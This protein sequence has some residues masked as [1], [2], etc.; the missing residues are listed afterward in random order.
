VGRLDRRGHGVVVLCTLLL[1]GGGGTVA[2]RA[3]VGPRVVYDLM[4]VDSRGLAQPAIG[5]PAISGSGRFVA[6][7]VAGEVI[8]GAYEGGIV[9]RDRATGKLVLASRSTAGAIGD[10]GAESPSL[11]A[12]GRYVAFAS[13]STNLIPNDRNNRTDVFVRDLLRRRTRRVDVTSAGS[14]VARGGWCPA[15]SA[16]GKSV[17]FLSDAANLTQ[18]DTPNTVDVFVHD[19][20]TGATE[21][22]TAIPPGYSQPG[23]AGCPA[24][25]ADGTRVAVVERLT[26]GWGAGQEAVVFDRRSGTAA[27]VS[28][29]EGRPTVVDK[30]QIRLSADGSTVAFVGP[31]ERLLVRRVAPGSRV[32]I[33]PAPRQLIV[34]IGGLSTDG[35]IVTYASGGD[36]SGGTPGLFE[37]NVRTARRIL[38]EPIGVAGGQS[39]IAGAPVAHG[40]L[41][42]FA[43]TQGL[44]PD[45]GSFGLSAY[46]AVV[47]PAAMSGE[48]APVV[49][50]RPAPAPSTAR[51]L[52][53]AATGRTSPSTDVELRWFADAVSGICRYQLAR[54]NDGGPWTS[55]PL[56]N[57]LVRRRV[58]PL[59]ASSVTYRFR[60]RAQA[61]N[62]ALSRWAIGPSF[63]AHPPAYRIT[64]LGHLMPK[65]QM[66]PTSINDLGQVVG[67]GDAVGHQVNA[68]EWSG[69]VLTD[70]GVPGEETV[71]WGIN[72]AGEV[73][74][75]RNEG[76]AAVRFLPKPE[77]EFGRGELFG[78]N[79]DGTAFGTDDFGGWFSLEPGGQQTALDVTSAVAINDSGTI[80]GSIGPYS[81]QQ[82]VLLSGTTTTVL[83][84]PQDA[85]SASGVALNNAGDVLVEAA[86]Q[87]SP[88]LWH[89]G[90]YA[91]LPMP[92][93]DP[94][95]RINATGMNDQ[96]QEVGSDDAGPLLWDS[97][98]VHE[99]FGMIAPGQHWRLAFAIDINQRGQIIGTGYHDGAPAAFLLT[100][101]N[102]G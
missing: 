72:N 76:V 23:P 59:P 55:V 28:E 63:R 89:D 98:G 41:V 32:V 56:A 47:D 30:N 100:P 86:D 65:G 33:H 92:Q 45:A 85:Q 15:I 26:S 19:L 79:L 38:V 31:G 78:V 67:M 57:R 82:P 49:S 66:F 7:A 35:S 70:L 6:L 48:S 61:C 60:V 22:L 12:N 75:T 68:F 40:R 53:L 91:T 2:A 14:G 3:A 52:A 8:P 9:V 20:Q 88:L 101:T 81:T 80:L 46:V 90:A 17:V 94:R 1:V 18:G 74:G 34:S 27:V 97:T 73:V 11:S 44:V 4:S 29:T 21:R 71:A 62:G 37:F 64:D 84:L 51:L 43:S 93:V 58:V 39:V 77:T 50:A 36:R 99:L 25:S 13:E 69:G 83:P 95:F 102:L 16:D 24:I 10:H 96:G 54:S 87:R 5:E 42:A